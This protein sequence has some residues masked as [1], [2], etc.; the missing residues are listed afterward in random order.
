MTGL[1]APCSPSAEAE[2][3]HERSAA[4]VDEQVAR[5]DVAMHQALGVGVVQGLG[6]GCHGIRRF[7]ERIADWARALARSLPSMYLDTIKQGKSGLL[8]TSYTGTMFAW[9]RLATA[10][11]SRR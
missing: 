4:L 8:P 10:R 5:L 7:A 6:H 9:S 11:A 1:A 3:G 2:I